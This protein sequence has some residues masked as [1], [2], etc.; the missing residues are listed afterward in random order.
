ML[1]EGYTV[2]PI[3]SE[4]RETKRRMMEIFRALQARP[5]IDQW[6]YDPEGPPINLESIVEEFNQEF[7]EEGQMIE[8]LPLS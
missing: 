2:Q 8:K 1:N 7:D 4:D 5:P 3:T 6:D